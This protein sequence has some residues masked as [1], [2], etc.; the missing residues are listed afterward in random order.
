MHNGLLNTLVQPL[1]CSFHLLFGGAPALT[2]IIRRHSSMSPKRK[3]SE[4][5]KCTMN[6]HRKQIKYLGVELF[7]DLDQV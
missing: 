6:K 4:E 5:E 1:F 2:S 3:N 7:K